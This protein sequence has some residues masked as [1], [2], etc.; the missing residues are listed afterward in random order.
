MLRLVVLVEFRDRLARFGYAYLEEAFAVRGT[1]I[2]VLEER[3][4]P[5]ATQELV[6]DMLAVVSVFAARLYGARG[7]KF[8][9]KVSGLVKEFAHGQS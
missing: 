4:A 3:E 9:Q 7:K 1:R 2:E 8:R 6:E 5:D